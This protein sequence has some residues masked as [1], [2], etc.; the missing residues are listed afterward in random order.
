MEDA[1]MPNRIALEIPHTTESRCIQDVV[2]VYLETDRK[3]KVGDT[4][5]LEPPVWGDEVRYIVLA[6]GEAPTSSEGEEFFPEIRLEKIETP[7]QDQ[8]QDQDPGSP[9]QTGA[10]SQRLVV[11]LNRLFRP[12]VPSSRET[13]SRLG[14]RK[15]RKTV[16]E[17]EKAADSL[18]RFGATSTWTLT[19]AWKNQSGSGLRWIRLEPEKPCRFLRPA[20]RNASHHITSH[21]ITSHHI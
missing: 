6:I 13:E 3:L 17:K 8:D 5:L 7:A 16:T 18:G 10:K 12:R 9:I 11:P 1:S 4:V 19:P 21:H 15:K 20:P 14:K 2:P